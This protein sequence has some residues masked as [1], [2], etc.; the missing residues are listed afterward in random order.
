MSVVIVDLDNFKQINDSHGHHIGDQVLEATAKQLQ[1]SL[2]N[3]DVLAR[4]CGEEFILFMFDTTIEAAV[5]VADSRSGSHSLELLILEADK[6]LY[7]AKQMGRK[8]V[9]T[10]AYSSG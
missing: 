3:G 4:W 7:S 8:R 5:H 6:C 9:A 1:D 2:L 10:M